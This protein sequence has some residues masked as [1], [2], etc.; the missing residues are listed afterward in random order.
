MRAGISE[1]AA[2]LRNREISSVELTK[3]YIDAIE[4]LNPTLNIYV[5][6]TFDT[7]LKAAEKAD[8]M[9]DEGDAPLICGIPM[10]LKDN[11]CTD[12][13][14]TTCC[15]RILKG[16]KPYY[17]A[18]VWEKLKKQ[19]A[20]LLGKAN[21]DEF[22]MGNTSETSCYGAP[23]NPRNTNYVTGG[24]S[25]GS[26][27]A[28]C[29]NLAVYS[30]GSDTGGSIRLPASFCGVVGLKPTYGAVSRYG[31]IAYGSSLDQIGPLTNSVKDAAIVFDAIK[32]GDR[33]DQTSVDH[34]YGSSLAEC[35]ERDVKGMRIGVAEE[36]F[37]GIN[38]EI[39]SS[40]DEAIKL[41]ERNGAIIENIS[42]PALKLALPV[43]YIIACAEASSNLGRYDGIRY[44]HRASSYTSIDDMITKTRSEGFGDEVKRRIMLG[45]YVL[46]SGYYDAYYKKA[47]LIR[48]EINREFDAVFEKCD[49]LIAPTAPNTAF[50]LNYKG[51][52]PV[53][54]YLADIC[55]VPVNIA[56]IP[57]ISI[58][59]GED[60]RGL[61]I[62][63]QIIGRRF[64]EATVLQA[65][66]FY[67][68][69]AGKV[70]DDYEGGAVI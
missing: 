14:P 60:S 35:L 36:F 59:C 32:G 20:V 58:P 51:A 23:L 42:L 11:I 3:A 6:L 53:E 16:F 34:D 22:A 29:A 19:G 7:A 18:T 48:E 69:S 61:P 9:L 49:V 25:G 28:V 13:L 5:Y 65:A 50:P 52:S 10:A 62:G 4:K 24:S 15:S 70:I 8:Q 66:H 56:G 55:T 54:M 63:M 57:A 67:E 31:L 68:Q 33:R 40:I 2:R 41:F 17:D 38:P 46:S 45:T 43:Y 64:G 47:C 26:A 12:G 44:G 30:L 21:M 39:K 1:L 37:D 27:A